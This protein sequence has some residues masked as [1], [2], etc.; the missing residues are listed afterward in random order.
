[1]KQENLIKI[2]ERLKSVFDEEDLNR[3]GRKTGQC[4]RLRIVTPQRLGLLM[5]SLFLSRRVKTIADIHRGFAALFGE[6]I[7]YKPF[8]NQ[9]CKAGFP[10]FMRALVIELMTRMAMKV[11]KPVRG[12]A[13]SMFKRIVIQDGSSFVLKDGLRKVYPGRFHNISPAAVELHLTYELLHEAAVQV[14]LRP[15]V[16]SEHLELPPAAELKG[17]LFLADRGYV[18]LPYFAR[19]AAGGVGFIVRGRRDLDPTVTAAR[20]E[21]GRKQKRLVGRGLKTTRGF[22]ESS[23]TDLDVRWNKVD[24][25]P[26]TLRMVVFWSPKEQRHSFLI[27]NLDRAKFSARQ[28]LEFYALRWQIELYFKE[29]K[30]YANLHA[31]DT[32]KENIAEGLIW[33]AIAAAICK[34]SSL[35]PRSYSRARRSQLR[36]SQCVST[37]SPTPCRSTRSAESQGP[38][39]SLRSRHLVSRRQRYAPHPKRDRTIGRL[40]RGLQPVFQCVKN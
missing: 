26:L 4:R 10:E 25:Q 15:D 16:D 24:G 17:A 11:L 18:N 31:F 39:G 14:A 35:M 22:P 30:S 8:H 23:V 40:A 9:L 7:K 34:H 3:L 29:W 19:L 6:G 32:E 12:G 36:R 5:V 21:S 37:T 38:A 20:D 1:M 13:L 2:T 27:T 33:A 28:V